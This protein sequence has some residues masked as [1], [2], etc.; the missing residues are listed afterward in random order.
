MQANFS[1]SIPLSFD[2]PPFDSNGADRVTFAPFVLY[3]ARNTESADLRLEFS[4]WKWLHDL[5][6]GDTLDDYYLNGP[7]VEGLVL[8]TRVLNRLEADSE[9]MELNSEGDACYIHFSD[10]EEAIETATLC[11]AMIKD[12][13]AIQKAAEVASENGWGD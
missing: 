4:N 9:T 5:C 12:R 3:D 8:A 10:F 1:G 6:G 7:G 2:D 11:A 13:R